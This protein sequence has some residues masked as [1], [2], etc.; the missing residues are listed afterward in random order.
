MD[1]FSKTGVMEVARNLKQI[2]LSVCIIRDLLKT[3]NDLRPKQPDQ[4]K[5]I[6]IQP[7]ALSEPARKMLKVC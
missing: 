4:A 7:R 6:Q 5:E 3:K 1:V 2:P